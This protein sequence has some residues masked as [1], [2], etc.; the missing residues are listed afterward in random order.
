MPR[1]GPTYYTPVRPGID[2][3]AAVQAERYFEV[4]TSATG[5][6]E[7]KRGSI[8]SPN[9]CRS[10]LLRDKEFER[11]GKDSVWPIPAQR[12][13]NSPVTSASFASPTAAPGRVRSIIRSAAPAPRSPRTCSVPGP[14]ATARRHIFDTITPCLPPTA[15]A[16]RR[17]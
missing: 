17:G 3:L 9:T 1:C 8:C 6:V 15:P 11:F 5:R 14:A 2:E 16:R 13:L 12:C 10:Q 4:A 7:P